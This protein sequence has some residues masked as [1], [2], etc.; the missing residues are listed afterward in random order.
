[1]RNSLV[2]L[3]VTSWHV[4]QWVSRASPHHS[5]PAFL[6]LNGIWKFQQCYFPE[7]NLFLSISHHKKQK[8]KLIGLNFINTLQYISILFVYF[9]IL[10]NENL[11]SFCKIF[12]GF[13]WDAQPCF[14]YGA[15][16]DLCRTEFFKLPSTVRFFCLYSLT[17]KSSFEFHQKF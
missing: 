14:R 6:N 2:L 13:Q 8:H 16:P 1:M 4:A 7:Y 11:E 3:K 17:M 12:L 9:V 15:A 10:F 5:L